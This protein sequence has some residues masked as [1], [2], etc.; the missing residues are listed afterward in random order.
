[1]SL[2]SIDLPRVTSIGESAFI[3]CESLTSIDLPRVTSVGNNAFRYCESLETINLPALREIGDSAFDSCKSLFQITLPASLESVG[4]AVFRLCTKLE[5]V[6]CYATTPP[7]WTGS[8]L[9]N[10]NGKPL[11]EGVPQTPNIKV[12]AS[13][14]A[15]YQANPNSCWGMYAARISAI[16]S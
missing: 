4:P 9:P 3:E 12:P 10:D 13:S 16:G 5:L 14:L 8:G 11:F 15:A 1:M 2:T 6:T 7:I